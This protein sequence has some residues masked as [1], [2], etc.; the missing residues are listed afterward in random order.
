VS[1][2]VEIKAASR[3]RIRIDSRLVTA[4]SDQDDRGR[5]WSGERLADAAPAVEPGH[6]LTPIAATKICTMQLDPVDAAG[7]GHANARA[8][9][10]PMNAATMPTT[11]SPDRDVLLAR[12]EQ[13]P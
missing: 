2:K 13:L 7:V 12:R 10:V 5:P 4:W 3:Q 1:A 6:Q 9:N 11:M 8:M